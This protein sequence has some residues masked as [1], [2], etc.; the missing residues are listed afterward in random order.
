MKTN[1]QTIKNKLTNETLWSWA[2]NVIQYF[3]TFVALPSQ[4]AMNPRSNKVTRCICKTRI[5]MKENT[6]KGWKWINNLLMNNRWCYNYNMLSHYC[7]AALVKTQLGR[8]INILDVFKL[9]L[10]QGF[11]C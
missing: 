10:S 6:V 2:F 5:R 3:Q 11:I 7:G 9:Q 1:K 4:L 8:A